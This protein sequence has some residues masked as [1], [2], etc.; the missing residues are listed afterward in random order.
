MFDKWLNVPAHYYLHLTALTILVVGVSTANVLMSIGTIWLI[1]NWLIEGRFNEKLERLKTRKTVWAILGLT[2][3]SF[4]TLFWS[5]NL[6]YGIHD[7]RIKLPFIVIPLVLGTAKP[8]SKKD[9]FRLIYFFIAGLLITSVIN[10][11]R[12]V[13]NIDVNKDIR[14]MSRFISHVR[15][16][17]LINFGIFFS[18]YV[19]LKQKQLRIYFVLPLLWFLFYQYK[20]Q[21]INGYALF[22]IL[23][24]ISLVFWISQ[25]KNKAFKRGIFI[26]LTVLTAAFF[27]S[28]FYLW[29]Q[30]P[31]EIDEVDF[32][33]LDLY[34][35]N[36]NGYYH[37]KNSTISEEGHLVYIY[38]SEKE[39]RKAWEKRSTLD[40]DGLD[41]KGQHLQGTLYRYMTS[42]NLRKDS[43]GFLSLSDQDIVNIENGFSNYKINNGL[44]EKIS[45]LKMQM[46]TYKDDGDPN[47]HSLMQR[48]IHLSTGFDILKANWLFG[49]GIGDVQASFDEQ[50]EANHSQLL[51]ENRHRSHNQFLTIW[52]SHGLIGFL[53]IL[54]LFIYPF[55]IHLFRCDYLLSVIL[56]SFAF[57]FLWQDMLETQAGVT[58]FSLFY[59]LVV[60][61]PK[62]NGS[63]G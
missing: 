48:Q 11:W 35:A 61:K 27:T 58:I 46:F 23:C 30:S 36:N 3:L 51:H 47:G 40:F 5:E 29:Y 28:V 9:F 15:Y 41:H 63:T 7:L 60:Y 20:S 14:E 18:Y 54:F 10:Y 34:T 32:S 22:I 31:S 53:L 4:I 33:T 59:S 12:Y 44:I 19:I 50:Y 26:G 52:I 62:P 25:F 38:I 21:T 37:V 45:N 39:C 55:K 1:A 43:L 13:Q 16:S 56:I 24:I 2:A 42:K 57:S 17:I 8:L 49:V 6:E